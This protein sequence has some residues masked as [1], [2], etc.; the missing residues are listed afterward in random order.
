MSRSLVPFPYCS[1]ISVLHEPPQFVGKPCARQLHS[2]YNHP[3]SPKYRH[4]TLDSS[5]SNFHP[6]GT[7]GKSDLS[8]SLTM[9]AA[10]QV[11]TSHCPHASRQPTDEEYLLDQTQD[12]TRETRNSDNT[13]EFIAWLHT[14]FSQIEFKL[15]PSIASIAFFTH[16]AFAIIIQLLCVGFL[17]RFKPSHWP[18][19]I[20]LLSLFLEPSLNILLALAQQVNFGHPSVDNV[21]R[22]LALTMTVQIV[23]WTFKCSEMVFR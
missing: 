15:N 8:L 10:V 4:Y 23:A 2:R 12:P 9:D 19:Q 11:I 17:T 7:T 14:S 3:S 1:P 22:G 6:I 21:V 18:S 5:I 20:F 13:N 16:H